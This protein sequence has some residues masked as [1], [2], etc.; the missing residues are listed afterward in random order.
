MKVS[1]EKVSDDVQ[2]YIQK[3][4]TRRAR[5]KEE[6]KPTKVETGSGYFSTLLIIYHGRTRAVSLLEKVSSAT[7]Q[8]Q[9]WPRIG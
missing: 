4:A 8:A 5:R 2:V 1:E 3:R 6:K 7:D 9:G